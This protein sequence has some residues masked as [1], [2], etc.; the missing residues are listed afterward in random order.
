MA[1]LTA[2]LKKSMD[3]IEDY[4]LKDKPFI[5]GDQISI[6]GLDNSYC[7]YHVYVCSYVAPM[8]ILH[9]PCLCIVMCPQ[10]FNSCVR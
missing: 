4:F 5:G 1:E 3:I 7:T 2:V 8:L 10:T 6:A 9:V